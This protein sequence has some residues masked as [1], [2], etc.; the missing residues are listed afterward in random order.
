M[1]TISS[2]VNRYGIRLESDTCGGNRVRV[3]VSV[4]EFFNLNHFT[5]LVLTHQPLFHGCSAVTSKMLKPQS[6]V[7][8]KLFNHYLAKEAVSTA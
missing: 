2:L 7:D 5:R 8:N 6:C 4:N 1:S 3:V